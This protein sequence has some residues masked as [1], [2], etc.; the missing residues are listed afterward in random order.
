MQWLIRVTNIQ[1]M[2]LYEKSDI[3]TR[4]FAQI[5]ANLTQ[6]ERDDLTLR[7][8]NAKCCKNRQ[9]IW[10]WGN[11]KCAP[12]EPLVREGVCKTVSRFLGARLSTQTLF[13]PR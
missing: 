3:D 4:T 8:Y 13:P 10:K 7:L 11:D 1:K 12:R 6:N 5:W 9:T 2:Q